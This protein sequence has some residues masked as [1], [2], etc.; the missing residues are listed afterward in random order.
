MIPRPWPGSCRRTAVAAAPA[1]AL[2][3]S[4]V[5][6][7]VWGQESPEPLT[8]AAAQSGV[9]IANLGTYSGRGFESEDSVEQEAAL[10]ELC[11]ALDLAQAV[12]A[13]SIRVSAVRHLLPPP[14]PSLPS[15]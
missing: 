12:G 5:T 6:L 8:S 10:A 1:A 11:A 3:R 15:P 2:T 14:H 7:C 13:R 4:C 9:Q